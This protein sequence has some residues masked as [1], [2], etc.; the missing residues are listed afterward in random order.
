MSQHEKE[1]IDRCI[2]SHYNMIKFH[3]LTS[4]SSELELSKVFNPNWGEL[5]IKFSEFE[6]NSIISKD[7]SWEKYIKT[8][9]NLEGNIEN[10]WDSIDR[11]NFK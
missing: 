1:L 6:F 7:K 8:F 9:E 5:K 10:D 2:E 4:E 3:D 11:C